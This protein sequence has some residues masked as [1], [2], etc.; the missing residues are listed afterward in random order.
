MG[1]GYKP[2]NKEPAAI[3]TVIGDNPAVTPATEQVLVNADETLQKKEYVADTFHNEVAVNSRRFVDVIADLKGFGEGAPVK[4]IYYKEHYAETDNHGRYHTEEH[5]HNVHR[6]VLKIIDFEIRLAG[7][8][9]YN[10]DQDDNLSKINY[11]AYTYP[12]F[13]PEQDD[14]LIMDIGDGRYGVFA[15]TKQPTRMSIRASTYFKI[16]LSLVHW[17]TEEFVQNLD[18]GVVSVA[19]FDKMRFLNEPGA[20]LI[21]DEV[22]EL[23]YCAKQRAK[24]IHYYQNKFMDEQIMYSFMR[25][26]NVYDPYVTDF[27]MKTLEFSELGTMSL[28]LYQGA[29]YMEMSIWRA[30]LD[31]NIPLEG[32]PTGAARTLYKLGSKSVLANSL[33][34][35]YYVRL[36]KSKSLKDY[37]KELLDAQGDGEGDGS[38]EGGDGGSS[39]E[40]PSDPSIPGM[41]ECPCGDGIIGDLLLHIHPHYCECPWVNG[42]TEDASGTTDSLGYI[43][44]EG[45]QFAFIC[46]LLLYRKIDLKLLHKLIEGIW[47][48]SPIEQFYVMPILIYAC[49][50]AQKYIHH[51]AAI[52]EP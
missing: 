15:V 51:D 4:V 39:S 52:F 14:K 13:R 17:A 16:E 6:S 22:V 47:K 42:E 18:A 27:L 34:N 28:Q 3:P 29:P 50:L 30:I 8:A 38:G 43:L 7:G 41:S 23:K 48:R 12:G 19:Y 45:D 11:E 46:A 37:L 35:K 40:I 36:V 21:H 1:F 5:L 24:M 9:Q 31:P 44:G 2:D 32:V 26:D 10:H 33:I 25:P 49:W 20:L